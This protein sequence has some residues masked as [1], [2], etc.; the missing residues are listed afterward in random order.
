MM[1]SLRMMLSLRGAGFAV[2]SEAEASNHGSNIKPR[3]LRSLRSLA[4]T[5]ELC[6][7][8]VKQ[9]QFVNLDT[10]YQKAGG[11]ANDVSR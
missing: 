1:S 7:S 3:L 8:A 2:L 10:L 4:M 11:W 9:R 5:I 6:V